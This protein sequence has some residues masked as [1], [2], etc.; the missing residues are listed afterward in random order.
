MPCPYA[1]RAISLRQLPTRKSRYFKVSEHITVAA[2]A[3]SV[4]RKSHNGG[5]LRAAIE[6]APPEMTINLID[7]APIPFYN[8]EMDLALA[9]QA[10]SNYRVSRPAWRC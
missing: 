9:Q 4:R 10:T 8:G 3:G 5:L 7:L 1:R 2:I 6:V